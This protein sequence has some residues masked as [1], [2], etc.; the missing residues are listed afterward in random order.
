VGKE[1]QLSQLEKDIE[2]PEFWNDSTSAQRVMKTVSSLRAE[3]EAWNLIKRQLHDL[4]EL[5]RLVVRRVGDRD[6]Q[7][8]G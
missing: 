6:R 3:V 7:P 4:T 2:H 1:L 8:R 5:A